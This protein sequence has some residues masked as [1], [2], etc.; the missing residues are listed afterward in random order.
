[1]CVRLSIL[2]GVLSIPVWFDEFAVGRKWFT[3][4]S[5]TPLGGGGGGGGGGSLGRLYPVLATARH[6][7]FLIL[8]CFSAHLRLVLSALS[9]VFLI[10]AALATTKR[11]K[12]KKKKKA[13]VAAV[14][15]SLFSAEGLVRLREASPRGD[16]SS[17]TPFRELECDI[18]GGASWQRRT[19]GCQHPG[20]A[21]LAAAFGLLCPGPIRFS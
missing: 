12:K 11:R 17:C 21:C 10:R 14:T 7:F 3:S 2:R 1:M 15:V 5:P 9:I 6:S 16:I 18:F 4:L 13:S 20:G 19:I 8:C